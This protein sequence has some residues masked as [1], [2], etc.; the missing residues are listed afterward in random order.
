MLHLIIALVT[1]V[2]VYIA[3]HT[4]TGKKIPTVPLK[5]LQNTNKIIWS[6]WHDTYYPVS[7]K[8]AYRSWRIT[9]P[10]YIICHV[11]PDNLEY[12]LDSKVHNVFPSN[13]S[14]LSHQHQADCIRLVL[15][16][17]YGGVWVDSTIYLFRNLNRTWND[18]YDLGGYYQDGFTTNHDA[19]VM[20]NWFISAPKGSKLIKDWKKEYF[21]ALSNRNYL[22]DI[23]TAGV[24]LQNTSN[25]EYLLQHCCFLAVLHWNK[26]YKVKALSSNNE[27]GPYCYLAKYD[28]NS[29]VA[30]D[31]LITEPL[32]PIPLMVKLRGSERAILDSKIGMINKKSVLYKY[33]K[34]K[35]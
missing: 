10:K 28:F 19:P 25:R 9:N 4:Y 5:A 21:S 17:K 29:K 22:Y 35:Y 20:E 18:D 32:R 2:A 31:K 8:M 15:I 3:Y 30:V 12:Y 7:V 11:N 6:Y 24:D 23:Q 1:L 34:S 13:F 26:G 33:L 14:S 16:E 27:R